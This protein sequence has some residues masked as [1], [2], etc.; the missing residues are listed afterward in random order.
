MANDRTP[1]LKPR[2]Y[3]RVQEEITLRDCR[4]IWKNFEGIAKQYNDAG[5][6]NF[7]IPLEED[8]AV[9]LYNAGWNVKEKVQEDGTHLYHLAV[10][11]KMDGKRPPR[12]FLITL[13]QMR[14]VQLKVEDDVDTVLLLDIAELDRV[15]VTLRPF[16]WDVNGKQGVSA[17]LKIL[18]GTVH[19]DELEKE[20]SHI[21]IDGA[22]DPSVLELENV[23]DAQVENETD[24]END[25]DDVN[26]I[27]SGM[28]ALTG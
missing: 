25:E 27:E 5:K 24:W 8:M 18:M 10:T 16:N 17:Y 6:R 9:E 3:K 11:V 2:P 12:M 14:R 28:K 4:M 23:I 26:A 15:D 7:A 22:S 20:Y 1:V 19:E 13:S 21:P